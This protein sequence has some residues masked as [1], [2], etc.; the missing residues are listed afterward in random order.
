[1]QA[2]YHTP[3]KSI[4]TLLFFISMNLL[5]WSDP[6]NAAS[7]PS[8]PAT[9]DAFRW[10]HRLLVIP[11]P[12][13]ELEAKIEKHR[14]AL[15]ERDLIVIRLTPDA[16]APIDTEIETSF[17]LTH[18]SEEILLIGKDGR[19]TVRWKTGEFTFDNL[20][21]RIDAMPMRQRE[22]RER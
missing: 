14:A 2:A 3:M 7:A 11:S 5:A 4:L 12:T 8:T 1:M 17:R 18:A 20:F 22:M 13:P 6:T 10:H 21:A 15:E 9:L 19:T 16:P